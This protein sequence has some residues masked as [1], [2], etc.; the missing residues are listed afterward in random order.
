MTG[1][2]PYRPAKMYPSWRTSLDPHRVSTL[3]RG[4]DVLEKT[5]LPL[6]P[7]ITE[8][9]FPVRFEMKSILKRSAL[10]GQRCARP[11]RSMLSGEAVFVVTDDFVRGGRV[12]NW[13]GIDPP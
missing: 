13:H 8:N 7:S 1:P 6:L 11:I 2:R 12:E 5:L 4:A 3:S 9:F 10:R